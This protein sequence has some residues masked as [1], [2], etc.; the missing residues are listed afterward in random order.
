MVLQCHMIVQANFWQRFQSLFSIVMFVKK[1]IVVLFNSEGF[2][3]SLHVEGKSD[4]NS[5]IG[6]LEVVKMNLQTLQVT[7][8]AFVCCLSTKLP[9]KTLI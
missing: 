9:K 4:I 1:H 8:F 5:D 7:S 6:C 3:E 2:A